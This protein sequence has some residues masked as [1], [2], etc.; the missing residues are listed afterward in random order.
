MVKT[1]DQFPDLDALDAKPTKKKDKKA[2]MSTPKREEE[3]VDNSTP[4]KGKPSA[5][6]VMSTDDAKKDQSNPFGY[7]LSQEQWSFMFLHYPEYAQSPYDMMT[8][9]MGEAKKKEDSEAQL[10]D[11]YSGAV[12]GHEDSDDEPR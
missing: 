7:N 11:A 10:N 12:H 1:E 6:F 3:E 2:Q 4:Y 9:L 5:F 8:W